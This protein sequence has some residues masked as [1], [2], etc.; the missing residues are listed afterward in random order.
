MIAKCRKLVIRIDLHVKKFHHNK[1]YV[2]QTKQRQWGDK[3]EARPYL[4]CIKHT[5]DGLKRKSKYKAGRPNV[6]YVPLLAVANIY[7][8]NKGSK[9]AIGYLKY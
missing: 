7:A 6:G 9:F 5:E 8:V 1:I 3:V 2:S 4:R